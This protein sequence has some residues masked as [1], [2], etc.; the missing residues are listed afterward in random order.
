MPVLESATRPQTTRC[1]A[2]PSIW[3]PEGITFEAISCHAFY[4]DS[5]AC[6]VEDVHARI[7]EHVPP[8]AISP[9]RWRGSTQF[10]A[11]GGAFL[12]ALGPYEIDGWEVVAV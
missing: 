5:T 1:R 3:E 8:I 12:Y 6:P 11:R 10:Y 2:G 7:T 9:W 4:R